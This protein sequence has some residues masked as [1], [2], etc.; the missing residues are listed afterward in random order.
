[1]SVRK[2]G[3]ILLYSFAGLVILMLLG[4][5]ALKL[6]LDRVPRYQAEIKGWVHRQTGY[7]VRFAHVA[8]AFHWYGPG[9]YFD[10]LELRSKDDRRVLARAAAGRIAA[11]LSQL[12]RGGK[13][14]S[15]RIEL[16]APNIIITRVG[17]NSFALASEIELGGGNSSIPTLTLDDLPAGELAIRQGLLTVENWSASLPRLVLEEVNLDLR[18]DR[19]GIAL[20]GSAR[21]PPVLG[22]TLS[23]AGN[24]RGLGDLPALRWSALIRARDISFPGWRQL[25]PDYLGSLDAGTGAFELAASGQNRSLARADLN[26]S[27]MGV[28]TQLPGGASAK[29][30]QIGGAL[31]LTHV[32]DRW[33]LLG[34]RVRA[35]VAGHRDPESEFDVAWRA[36][37]AGLLDLQAR[38]SYLR[39]ES[40]LPL[41]GL[42]PQADI[43]DRL[44][45]VAPTGEWV[46]S[47]FSLSR[48]TLSDPWRLQARATFRDAG[49][50]P[51]SRVPG[52]RGLSGTIAGNESG[53]HI[54]IDTHSAVF[55]WPRQLPQ[56]IDL[57]TL[58]TTL[59]WKRSAEALLV[60]TPNIEIANADVSARGKAAWQQPAD[61]SSPVLTVV[62]AVDNG[63]MANARNYFPRELLALP[64]LAWL[65]RAFVAGHL[66]H[67]DAIIQGPVR[68]FP[69]RDGSGQFLVTL[70]ADGMTL[71]YSA[72]WQP[73]ENLALQAE[74]RNQG[75]TAK[76]L[77][78]RVGNL[79]LARGDAR[80]ADFKTGELEVHATASSDASDAL[81]YLRATPLDAMADH[82]FSGVDA[83]GPL[84]S[85]VDLFLPFKEF[86]KRRELVHLHLNGVTLNRPGSTLAATELS[87]D[88]DIDGAQVSHAEIRGRLLGG[89]FQMT[90]RAPRN[91]PL[92]RTQLDFRG[93]MT[94]EALHAALSL[95][96]NVVINGQ[97]DWH[98]VLR[99]AP[100][101]A[102]ERSLRVSGSL[103]G[104]ELKLP[105]PLS[106]PAGSSMPSWMDVQ[107]PPSGVALIRFDLGAV[108]RGALTV[109]SDANGP[110]L[111]RAALM[112]G[113]A[114]PAFSDTQMINVGG[115]IEELDLAGWLKLNTPDKNAKPLANY[116]RTAKLEVG[117]LDYLG[118]S[119]LNVSLDLAVSEAGMRVSVGGPNVAGTLNMPGPA[120]SAAPWNL[121]FERLRFVDGPSGEGA[122]G[123]QKNGGDPRG[124]PAIIFHAAELTW[125]DRHF[126]DVHAT[127]AK[128]DDGISLKQLIV[129][130]ANYSVDAKGEWRG[131]DAGLGRVEGN[132]ISTD[133]GGTLKQLGYAEVIEAKTGR[134]DF[135]MN[136]VGAPTADSL[137]DAVG[138]V[139]IALGKGQIVGLKPGA[140][141]VLGLASV[142]ELPRRLALDFSDVTDKGFAFDTARG[143]FDLRG[144]NAYTDNV[145]V[146]GPAAEI[147]LI[148]RVGLKNKDYDQTAAVTGSLGSSPLPLAGF[149]GGP[150][151]GAAVLVFSQ[152]FKQ[153]LKGLVR[154]YYRITGSW[155]NPTVERIK[156][157]DAAGATAGAPK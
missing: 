61:G 157:A 11:D 116:L 126:G 1:M 85:K 128:L 144:G 41:A 88:A 60:A 21:L 112:F 66:S 86:D 51:V 140:G 39:I 64:A 28:A 2:T 35:V 54:D 92:T 20:D 148:G 79:K 108:L 12:F 13:I 114:E 103:A 117:R 123:D 69:F 38:A 98:G 3:K 99:M 155:D 87:G 8:P 29:F 125:D 110:R 68:Q 49:F 62:G 78:G 122:P 34:R 19:A 150:V 83:K 14:L 138:H 7:Y 45:E 137:R 46:D 89:G 47:Y 130:G 120:D 107:W 141:R 43:R 81:A 33:T 153:P 97:T 16:D 72:G 136:W 118:L 82:A 151:L 6:A 105:A 109:E 5:L 84:E 121:Q 124:I 50:A 4:V 70:A 149:V 127:L 143:D 67:A 32:G 18:R 26:F 115:S 94:G 91:R 134:M 113:T 119:F 57:K 44:R 156:S 154:G 100:G 40:L 42:V 152:V 101:P 55:S 133:V 23:V 56:P 131:P 146:K 145:L 25:F 65:N 102:R 139:Q 104:L 90:A 31:T 52:L 53:G 58:K 135:D 142:A 17:P 132:L 27:A 30:E 22:G 36:G 59:Y 80:F 111:G 63:N 48:A 93:T 106:K 10:Q 15:E 77:G 75:F 9:L 129:T 147:G 24:A 95:P 74:F 71:D 96:G 76:L 73:A 37:D